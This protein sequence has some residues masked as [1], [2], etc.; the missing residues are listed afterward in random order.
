[1]SRPQRH[2]RLSR[3]LQSRLGQSDSGFLFGLRTAAHQVVF[4]A[5][6]NRAFHAMVC[7]PG[8]S[9][10]REL[11]GSQ[12]R[13]VDCSGHKARQDWGFIGL[14]CLVGKPFLFRLSNE[15]SEV[16]LEPCILRLIHSWG[17]DSFVRIC[18]S[19]TSLTASLSYLSA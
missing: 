19:L 14:L 1:M 17:F 18:F 12:S 3:H 7:L 4:G 2:R 5:E 10:V 8:S 9:L 13:D 16:F 11:G 6:R 15:A